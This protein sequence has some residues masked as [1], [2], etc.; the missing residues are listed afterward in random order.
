MFSI[1]CTRTCMFFIVA[2]IIFISPYNSAL[3]S[4]YKQYRSQRILLIERE[5]KRKDLPEFDRRNLELARKYEETS[6]RFV[7]KQDYADFLNTLNAVVTQTGNRLESVRPSDKKADE[8]SIISVDLVKLNFVGKFSSLISFLE[9]L[10][11]QQKFLSIKEV[12]ISRDKENNLLNIEL[13]IEF[14]LLI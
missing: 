11:K 8:S 4:I 5:Q 14:Y 3:G 7:K 9:G 1:A 13:A 10:Q 12:Q 6:W 2:Y